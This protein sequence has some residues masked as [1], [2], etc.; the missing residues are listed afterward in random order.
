M[1]LYE[2]VRQ[3]PGRADETLSDRDTAEGDFVTI[4]ATP[5]GLSRV[6]TGRG[7][8]SG[9]TRESSF[10]HHLTGSSNAAT[11]RTD[12]PANRQNSDV[13]SPLTTRLLRGEKDGC[14]LDDLGPLAATDDARSDRPLGT[15][16]LNGYPPNA[17][18]W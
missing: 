1:P 18:P 3:V 7:Q 17:P 8:P 15:R 2:C 14:C 4:R 6:S 16:A 9:R 12:A 5:R 10:V 13:R 11:Q